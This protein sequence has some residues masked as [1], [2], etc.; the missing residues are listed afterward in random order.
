MMRRVAVVSLLLFAAT[1]TTFAQSQRGTIVG[2]ITDA[3]GA[4]V[5]DAK[6]EVVH[7]ETNAKR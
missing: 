2:T 3:T 7:S 4:V 5:P 1:F 6:V